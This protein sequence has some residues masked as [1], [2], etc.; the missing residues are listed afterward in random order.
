[1]EKLDRFLNILMGSFFGVFIGNLIYY[2][3]R[4]HQHPDLYALRS[5]PWYYDVLPSLFL[6]L[7]TAA[8]CLIVKRRLRRKKETAY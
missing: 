7:I 2:Y 4:F 3:R 8:I 6:F 5:A 1:M